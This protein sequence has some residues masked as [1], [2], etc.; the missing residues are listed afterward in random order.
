MKNS[1]RFGNLLLL[2]ILIALIA[3]MCSCSSTKKSGAYCATYQNSF[4][5]KPNKQ[6]GKYSGTFKI[7]KIKKPVKRMNTGFCYAKKSK[8]RSF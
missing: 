3:I 8:K 7:V 6:I 1:K 2:S 5:V 4:K